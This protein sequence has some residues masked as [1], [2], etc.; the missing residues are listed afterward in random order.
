MTDSA[1]LGCDQIRPL[2]RHYMQNRLFIFFVHSCTDNER[3]DESIQYLHQLIGWMDEF[4]CPNLLILLNKQDLLP[5]AERETI[6]SGLRQRFEA[7]IAQYGDKHTIKVMD[8]PGLSGRTG[9]Q[10]DVI[11]DEVVTVIQ[12][13]KKK[14]PTPS[15]APP[16]N[17]E[18]EK[19]PSDEELRER[20]KKANATSD[21]PDEFWKSFL[22]GDLEAWDHH[23]HLRAGFFV[24]HDCFARG[25]N[26][27][28]CADE[29]IAHLT[30]LREKK[31]DRF[32]NTAHRYFG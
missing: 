9:A 30:R 3:L 7:E 13:D 22:S 32:R 16:K 20:I 27:F 19:G 2:T 28:E 5:P 10:L 1:S 8:T 24:I 4:C 26:I 29:F 31:P 18:L 25:R 17:P 14:K 21:S 23:T 12:G 11:M 15:T 6:V